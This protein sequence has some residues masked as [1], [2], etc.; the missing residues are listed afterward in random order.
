MRRGQ[1][2]VREEGRHA[3]GG[4]AAELDEALLQLRVR[5]DLAVDAELAAGVPVDLVADVGPQ[6]TVRVAVRWSKFTRPRT[7]MPIASSARLN[8][9]RK[10]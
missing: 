10:P 4:E 3:T 7:R 5:R 1:V 8:V 6:E 9:S 2:G